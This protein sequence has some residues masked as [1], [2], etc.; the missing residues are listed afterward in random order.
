MHAENAGIL[1]GVAGRLIEN[2][3]ID[4]AGGLAVQG[5]AIKA[6]YFCRNRT[7]EDRGGVASLR[8]ERPAA[9]HV[10]PSSPFC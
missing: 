9:Q 6:A 7:D 2:L 4:T 1:I 8:H 3:K 5:Q 10:H